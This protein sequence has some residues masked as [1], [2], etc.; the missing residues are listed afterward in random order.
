MKYRIVC[1]NRTPATREVLDC[2]Y[3]QIKLLNVLWIDCSVLNYFNTE[4]WSKTWDYDFDVAEYFLKEMMSR[5]E[6]IKQTVIKTYDD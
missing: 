1:R 3:I 5:K 4:K 2:Y 6:P